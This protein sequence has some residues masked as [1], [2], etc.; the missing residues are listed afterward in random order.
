[1]ANFKQPPVSQPHL[2]ARRLVAGRVAGARLANRG[3]CAFTP[4]PIAKGVERAL[5]AARPRA[6]RMFTLHFASHHRGGHTLHNLAPDVEFR[7]CPRPGA[8]G[9][10]GY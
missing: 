1:M 10:A 5:S 6:G 9:A 2:P 8:A 4:R 3:G 7:P